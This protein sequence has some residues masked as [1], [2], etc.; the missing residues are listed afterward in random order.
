MVLGDLAI[1]GDR[2]A[3]RVDAGRR[4]GG[5]AA[6]PDQRGT[7]QLLV[8]QRDAAAGGGVAVAVERVALVALLV[9]PEAV[10]PLLS[11]LVVVD[12]HCEVPV[13]GVPT[14]W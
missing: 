9:P 5:A 12:G 8:F 7:H 1:G 3:Q 6:L 13:G 11:F 10:A 4:R 14:T 2:L